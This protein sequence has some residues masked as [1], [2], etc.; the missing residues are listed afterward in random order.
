VSKTRSSIFR[1]ALQVSP[2]RIA[3]M[4]D[5]DLDLLMSQLLKAQAYKCGSPLNKI[6][7]NTEGKAKD[8]GCD[9]WSAKPATPDNWLGSADTC[10]QLKAGKAGEPSR[11]AGEVTKRIPKETLDS[12]GRFVVVASGSK[13]GKKGE[14]DRLATLT[15]EAET[16][17]IPIAKIEVI[18]SERLTNWC[19]QHPA[20]AAYWAGHPDG[21]W[22]LDDWSKSDEHQVPW[23]ASTPVQTELV[24]QR[25]NLDFAIGSIYHLHIQGPPGVGKTR[26]ALELCREAPWRTKVIYIRQAADLRLVE[27]IDGVAADDGVQLIVV[28][29]EVQA[30]QLTPLRDSVGRGNGRVRLITVGHSNTPDPARIPTLLVKPLDRQVMGEVVRGWHPAMPP[31]HVDFV[32]RFADGYV[33]LARLAAGAVAK[34]P[35]MD[36]RGLLNREEIRGFLNGMLGKGDRQA[37]Y[38]VAVL[39]SVGWI[40]DKQN[41][42]EEVAKHFGLD[43]NLVRH[44]VDDFHNRLGI[45]P[46]GGRYR[47]ISPTPLG[48]HLA[49]EAWNTYPDLLKSL[50][51]I[52][53]EGAIDAY[54]ERLQSMASNPQ[55]REYAREELS[56]FFHIDDFVDVRAVRRWSALSSADPEEAARNILRALTSASLEDR[57][58][59]E[60]RARRESVWTLVRLAWNPSSFHDACLAMALLAEAENET[61]ANNASAEFVARFQIS[62]GGTAVPYLDRLTVLNELLSEERPSLVSLVV[63]ALAQVGN[64][65]D[66]RIDSTPASDELPER[67]WRPITPREYFECVETAITMLSDIA[68]CGMTDIQEDLIAAA[69]SLS[70]LLREPTLSGFVESFFDTV[71]NAYPEAREPLRK[72]IANI[73]HRERKYWKELSAQNLEELET[74]HTRFEGPDLGAR[75]QQHVGQGP[76]DLEEEPDLRTLA[77][78]LLLAPEVLAEYWPWLTSGDAPE[79]WRL[80][81][82]LAEVDSDGELAETLPLLRGGGHDLRLL[83]GYISARR[84]ALGDEWYD[85]WIASQIER[86]P[87]PLAVLFA[88]AWR[89]GATEYVA[90]MVAQ[91]LRSEQVSPQIVGQF[92]F[93]RWGENLAVE[94]LETVLRA[95]AETGHCEVAIGILEYRMKSKSTEAKHWKPLALE[96]V[97]SSNL[98]RGGDMTNYYWKQVADML[99]ADYPREIAAAIIREQADFKSGYWS[100]D[101]S[102]ASAILHACVE[103]DP[104]GVWEA[105]KSHLSSQYGAHMFSIGFPR[106]VLERMPPDDVAAWVVENPEERAVMVARLASKNIS[107]D[108]TLAAR[109]LG[110]YGDNEHVAGAF[111]STYMSGSYS[112]LSSSHW[113]Q[114]AQELNAV[115]KRTKLPKLRRWASDSARSLRK[116][117]QRDQQRE[118]EEELR[119]R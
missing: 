104:S 99:V 39:T 67:E 93:G 19:N 68:E 69:K 43:W 108:E 74:L 100:A 66:T 116:M 22:S 65:R 42:G 113:N 61:W 88:V 86:E 112:G 41:E 77:G 106:G 33:R 118:E 40:D 48:I 59:I 58:R 37:L 32:V 4:S 94:V 27:L 103:Q 15:S 81:E 14:Q 46:R 44:I 6:C 23:Q 25:A 60:E 84:H 101:N 82:T 109:L 75:L 21:L 55:A 87:K 11:L 7:V 49:V 91:I 29:D 5:G 17:K 9:G 95:M 114:F 51:G 97:T 90:R 18:G 56:F 79:S 36:V 92:L 96:L 50:P 102:E 107:T 45:A 83:C 89:C 71:R 76:W 12:G 80:G 63:K 38:V 110:K 78:E 54:Y 53:P 24:A 35:T 62:L 111:F 30:E 3:A 47:Y 31:E 1:N 57:R 16:A 117:A 13:N 34:S 2:E 20:V 8:D 26:F 72:A 70:M 52:L 119:G 10:W 115:A 64:Q 105:M 85:R 28:A 98:I 73:V